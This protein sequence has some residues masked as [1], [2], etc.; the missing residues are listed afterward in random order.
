[1]EVPYQKEK[2]EKGKKGPSPIPQRRRSHK[3]ALPSVEVS[4]PKERG[5]GASLVGIRRTGE[6]GGKG[7]HGGDV[8]PLLV[9]TIKSTFPS[10]LRKSKKKKKRKVCDQ[11][12]GKFPSRYR[13]KDQGG[14]KESVLTIAVEVKR[15]KKGEE[16]VECG[17]KEPKNDNPAHLYWERK[18]AIEIR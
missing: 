15:Q 16:V 13:V 7:K 4:H 6:G 5:T 11:N 8:K 12:G 2:S 9:L 1:V 17:L 3:S 14:K 18:R 10:P